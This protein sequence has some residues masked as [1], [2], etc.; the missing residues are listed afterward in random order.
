MTEPPIPVLRLEALDGSGGVVDS[1]LLPSAHTSERPTARIGGLAEIGRLEGH[2]PATDPAQTPVLVGPFRVDVSIKTIAAGT[3]SDVILDVVN[4]SGTPFSGHL[5]LRAEVRDAADPWWLIPGLFYG[6]NRPEACDRRF[7]R[8]EAGASDP[9]GMVSD[10]WSF[11]SDRAA[12]PAVFAW[13]SRG[14]VVVMT[15]ET[16]PCGLTGVGLTHTGDVAGVHVDFPFREEP[17]TYYGSAEP[18]APEAGRYTWAPG[19][20]VRL[21]ASVGR[22][23]A[24]RHAYAP[25]LRDVHDRNRAEHPIEPWTS[26]PDAADIAAEGLVRWHYDPDPGVLLETVGF[27]REVTGGDG[28]RVDRQAMHVGW[29]SG[30]P[31]A[32]ALLAHGRRSRAERIEEQV[33]E[34]GPAEQIAAAERVIDFICSNL[35]PSG[36]FWGTWY[37]SKG[38]SQS[39]TPIRDGLHARTLGEATLFVL[40]ALELG[41]DVRAAHPLWEVAARSN[42]D[43]IADRQRGDGNVGSVHHAHDGRVL[44]WEGASGLTWVAALAEA[45]RYDDGRYLAA[46]VRAGEYYA[47]FVEREFIHGA[48][49]DVDLAPTSEDGYAAV[50]AYVALHR[51]TGEDRWL[52]LA[53]RAAEWMLTFRYTYNVEFTPRSPLGVY[54]FA[55]RGSDQASPSNQHVHAYGLVCTRELLELSEATGDPHFRERAEET[56]AC[57][58]QL[59]ASEDGEVNSYRGMVTE[60]YYQTSCFQPKG[61]LLTLSHAWSVG[62]LLLGCEQLL[63]H[64]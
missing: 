14:G 37:R 20:P 19:E 8:F 26:V 50:M 34:Y 11:R 21:N 24:D 39:W 42:L 29:V 57:F 55:T 54:G 59:I 1:V 44:S 3:P 60:R 62:V 35:S 64:G 17:V 51:R 15:N 61:M 56:L 33:A 16:S 41:D 30:V 43:A 18:R 31:W 45:E 49:E 12:T 9:D 47:Q 4:R 5:R 6:E 10:R 58:R 13:G 23:A 48:P 53:R 2:T 63:N 38:W 36:T 46:A 25:V 28:S 27:D 7:P 22:L 52:E 32:Y 40:R